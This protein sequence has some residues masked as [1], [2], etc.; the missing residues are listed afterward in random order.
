MY[1]VTRK[2]RIKEDLQLCHANGDVALTVSVDLNIDEMGGRLNKA[3]ETF[4]NAQGIL[5]KGNTGPEAVEAYGRAVIALFDVIF[6]EEDSRKIIAFYE[7]NY[8]EMLLDLFPFINDEIMPKV[9]EASAE[10]KAQL[11]RATQT[12]E[13]SNT[14]GKTLLEKIKAL[15]Q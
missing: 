9:R 1:S 14:D 12:A 7:D 3:L 10:R 6:G 5:Q 13:E 4:A 11:L 8:T 15:F 2:N